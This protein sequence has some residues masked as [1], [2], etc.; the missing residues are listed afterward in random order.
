[1]DI[2]DSVATEWPLQVYSGVN[3]VWHSIIVYYSVT[4]TDYACVSPRIDVAF[5]DSDLK[6][7]TEYFVVRDNENKDIS[8][9]CNNDDTTITCS[10]WKYCLSNHSL[11]TSSIEYGHS[12]KIT[13]SVSNAVANTCP[14]TVLIN[15]TLYCQPDEQL[16]NNVFFLSLI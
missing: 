10:I 13:F 7:D 16:S 1:M 9:H 14:N 8:G 11:N 4:S 12:Y 2:T 6:W 5:I 3:N 15:V